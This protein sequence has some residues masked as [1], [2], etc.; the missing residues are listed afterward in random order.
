[1]NRRTAVLGS[2][3]VQ[4]SVPAKFNLRPF[5]VTSLDSAQAVAI[6][7]HD[8]A[9]IPQTPAA[10]FGRLGQLL[11]LGRRQVFAAAQ[12]GI[13][14]PAGHSGLNLPVYVTWL[15]QFKMRIHWG[16]PRFPRST[17]RIMY[18]LR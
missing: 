18:L 9:D 10:V 7:H 2:A 1:V 15:D 16:I 6:G 12:V 8:Q 3:D 17:Y 11:D 14:R 13:G 4:R 5:E